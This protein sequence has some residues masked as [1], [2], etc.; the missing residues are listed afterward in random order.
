MSEA[1][2][3]I[4]VKPY[5]SGW[6]P[7]RIEGASK[8]TPDVN[9]KV[10]WVELKKLE[11][12]PTRPDTPVTVE[13]YTA[14]QRVWHMRRCHAG[15]CCHVLIEIGGSSLL[16]WGAVAAEHLGRVPRRELIELADAV[17]PKGSQAMR[18]ELKDAI[19]QSHKR[20]TTA[21]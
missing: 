4:K 21:C 9:N 5:L 2:Y 18:G 12:W 1:S 13:H 10:G 19:L 15:G 17:W 3:W 11:K 16:L 8:G 7:V 6:D 14:E 20:R